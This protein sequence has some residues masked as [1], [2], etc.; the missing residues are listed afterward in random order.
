MHMSLST[1]QGLKNLVVNFLELGCG[2]MVVDQMPS[3]L[4]NRL[5]ERP[6]LAEFVT[7]DYEIH[8]Q[9][10]LHSSPC[11]NLLICFS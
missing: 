8:L 9:K 7:K 4:G 5:F 1:V 3:K 2:G 10:S 6:L 11:K